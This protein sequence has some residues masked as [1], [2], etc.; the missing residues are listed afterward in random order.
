MDEG[1]TANRNPRSLHPPSRRPQIALGVV[2]A[3][4]VT[5][6]AAQTATSPGADP[7]WS[8]PLA[9]IQPGDASLALEIRNEVTSLGSLV[10]LAAVLDGSL[11]FRET[12]WQPGQQRSL[13]FSTTGG[14]HRLCVVAA[15]KGGPAAAEGSFY[16]RAPRLID[17]VPGTAVP[18]RVSLQERLGAEPYVTAQYTGG[19]P[20]AATTSEPDPE[21]YIS[22]LDELC[23]GQW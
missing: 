17:L 18:V 4:A 5:S 19:S 6:C 22:R 9:S 15:Y 16:V 1:S 12:N 23:A 11:L 7:V 8:K 20:Y 13:G 3:V 14:R 21:K 2:L 10:G